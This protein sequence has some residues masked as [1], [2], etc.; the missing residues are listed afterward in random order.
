MW[1][2]LHGNTAAL[3][4]KKRQNKYS[5]KFRKWRSTRTRTRSNYRP[6]LTK[7]TLYIFYHLLPWLLRFYS[8]FTHP[9][10]ARLPGRGCPR[11]ANARSRKTAS[12]CLL[13]RLGAPMAFF[14]SK[15]IDIDRHGKLYRILVQILWHPDVGYVFRTHRKPYPYFQAIC[16]GCKVWLVP[17]NHSD[18]QSLI[19]CSPCSP[20]IDAGN[21]GQND[22]EMWPLINRSMYNIYI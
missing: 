21:G 16:D 4:H 7:K 10:W 12:G 3:G 2:A 19:P 11:I 13:G 20:W 9:N 17:K 8:C 1:V 22:Y 14:V 6:V 18:C 5:A 15:S